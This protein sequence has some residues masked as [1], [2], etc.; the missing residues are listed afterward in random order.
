MYDFLFFFDLPSESESLEITF[1]FP[2]VDFFTAGLP[3]GFFFGAVP[4]F[5]MTSF[6]F[7]IFALLL[8]EEAFKGEA[9]VVSFFSGFFV[10]DGD[11]VASKVLDDLVADLL[12][13]L[14]LPV[15]GVMSI[16][17][18]LIFFIL[19][20]IC[21]SRQDLM[22]SFIFLLASSSSSSFMDSTLFSSPALDLKNL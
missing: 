11:S 18:W 1:F 13:D 7:A 4:S 5:V 12:G 9:F 22:W 19:T 17:E 6:D 8:E 20:D 21:L 16:S 14:L 3:T 15:D 2:V 10:A